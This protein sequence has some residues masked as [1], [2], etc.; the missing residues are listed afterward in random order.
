MN[1]LKYLENMHTLFLEYFLME[2]N[3]NS[4]FIDFSRRWASILCNILAPLCFCQYGRNDNIFQ[5][6]KKKIG[7]YQRFVLKYLFFLSQFI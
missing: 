3:S 1:I 7:V 5:G 4:V 6:L 2:I